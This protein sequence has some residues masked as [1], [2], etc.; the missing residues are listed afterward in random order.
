MLLLKHRPQS[1]LVFCNTRKESDEVAL[2]LR[3]HGFAAQALHGDL[4]QRARDQMLV[5][6]ANR[7]I[8]ALVA[9][10]VAA[11]GLDI[12]DLDLVINYH[13]AR[14]PEVHVH[15]VGRTGRA[16]ARGT[17][18]SL[19]TARE[20]Y[21]LERLEDSLGQPLESEPLPSYDL[22]KKPAYRPAM[23]TLQIDGGRKPKVR[24]GD[25]LGAL[26]GANGIAG[27]QVGKISIFDYCAYVAV[28]RDA[29]KP[30]LRKLGEGQIKGRSFRV[31][32]INVNR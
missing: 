15:R 11:R 8:S 25:V 23:V 5:C 6:F 19:F 32:R 26:T 13:L 24:P 10:D 30:A 12:D 28:E 16:G 3:T 2:E 1:A 31:R 20:T 14:E 9:T 21:K 29:A 18:C 22:L 17:A 27:K 4:D 7:S